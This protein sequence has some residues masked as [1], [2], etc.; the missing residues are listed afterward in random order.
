MTIYIC[1]QDV[2]IW[3]F[4]PD[5]SYNLLKIITYTPDEMK[6]HPDNRY[7]TTSWILKQFQSS[8]VME[9]LHHISLY[10]KS[11]GVLKPESLIRDEIKF[12][13]RFRRVDDKSGTIVLGWRE[14]DEFFAIKS[15]VLGIAFFLTGQYTYYEGEN[16]YPKFKDFLKM[17]EKEFNDKCYYRNYEFYDDSDFNQFKQGKYLVRQNKNHYNTNIIDAMIDCYLQFDVNVLYMDDYLC[18]WNDYY[19]FIPK[20][21][22][23]LINLLRTLIDLKNDTNTFETVKIKENSFKV[24][25]NFKNYIKNFPMIDDEFTEDEDDESKEEIEN[26]ESRDESENDEYS[27]GSDEEEEEEVQEIISEKEG[28]LGMILNFFRR[29]DGLDTIDS[30]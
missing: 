24:Y 23:K 9:G 14:K 15:K 1:Y 12:F 26:D 27:H 4:C 19:W 7:G 18:C 22:F 3:N 10:L 13:K 8:L 11:R 17:E 6:L 28:I 5:K 20:D 29:H 21:E 16:E 30:K 2:E 25:L